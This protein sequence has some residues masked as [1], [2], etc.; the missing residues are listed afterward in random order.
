M[1]GRPRAHCKWLF[2][3]L[4][5][6]VAAQGAGAEPRVVESLDIAPVWAGHPAGF[7]LLTHPPHQ[8]AAFYAADRALTVAQR[9]LDAREWQFTTLPEAIGWDSHNYVTM[10]IDDGGYLHLAGN[11]HCHPL[12]YFRTTAPLDAATFARVPAMTGADEDRCTYPHFFRGPENAFLFTY[13]IGKSGDGN[14]IY[15]VYDVETQT[16]QRLLDTPLTNGEGQRNAYFNGPAEGP[17]GYWHLCWIWRETYDCATNN[18]IC[19]ARSKD[20]RNWESAAGAPLERPITRASSDVVDPVPEGGGAINGNVA[21]GFDLD[22]RPVVSYH[23]YDE[24]GITQLYNAR[25]EDGSWRAHLAS[26]WDYRWEFGGGG[27]IGFEI[28]IGPVGAEDGALTQYWRHPRRGGQTWQLDPATLT[29]LKRVET[30]RD[31]TPGF[32]PIES[33][34]PGMQRRVRGDDGDSGAPGVAY[35]LRWE[36]LGPNRDRPREKPWPEPSMLRL[37]EA[38]GQ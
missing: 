16:W 9:R 1:T 27:A 22:G 10:A 33:G 37:I 19:Y 12:K 30:P 2:V 13:R 26:D 32:G 25:F 38:K 23:K 17:D 36:T 31:E 35:W 6:T 34:F 21:L 18:T 29:P 20:L 7:C 28:R 11:M 14:Q 8:F 5:L 4:C 3:A 24:N 15:N